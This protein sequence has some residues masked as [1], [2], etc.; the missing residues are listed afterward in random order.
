MY[1]HKDRLV[2]KKLLE[3]KEMAFKKWKMLS[4]QVRVVLNTLMLFPLEDCTHKYLKIFSTDF[5]FIQ[6]KIL[7]TTRIVRLIL[8]HY[9][10]NKKILVFD[11]SFRHHRGWMC[12]SAIM[13]RIQVCSFNDT[14]RF[15]QCQKFEIQELINRGH[16]GL[17]WWFIC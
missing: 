2:W 1:W 4:E 15:I 14:R 9:L 13:Y 6:Q 17:D 10:Y 16:S 3:N 11:L 5:T 8:G 7:L 12:L